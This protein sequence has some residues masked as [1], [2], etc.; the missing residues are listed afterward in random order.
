MSA[1]LQKHVP[2]LGENATLFSLLAAYQ[3]EP[4]LARYHLE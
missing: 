3:A 4:D 1:L 2:E